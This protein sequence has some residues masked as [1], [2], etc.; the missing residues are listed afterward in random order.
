MLKSQ[1]DWVLLIIGCFIAVAALLADIF[2]WRAWWAVAPQ[3]AVT[4]WLLWMARNF[5]RGHREQMER[6][7]REDGGPASG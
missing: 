5:Y 1:F 6:T 4:G 7:G 2:I 3:T